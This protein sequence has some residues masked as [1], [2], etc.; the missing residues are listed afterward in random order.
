MKRH[1]V[2]RWKGATESF[3]ALATLKRQT[4]IWADFHGYFELTKDKLAQQE[5][6]PWGWWHNCSGVAA[7]AANNGPCVA[8]A[9]QDVQSSPWARK[10]R[11]P[12]PVSQK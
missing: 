12:R 4:S 9:S 7:T 8:V 10:I 5:L 2:R 1:Q 6:W 11:V 3:L